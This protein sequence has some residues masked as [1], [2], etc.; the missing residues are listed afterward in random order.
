MAS[1]PDGHRALPVEDISSFDDEDGR[2]LLQ[3]TGDG[4]P[5]ENL[6]ICQVRIFQGNLT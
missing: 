3:E 2:A 1:V 5:V 4:E 6:K